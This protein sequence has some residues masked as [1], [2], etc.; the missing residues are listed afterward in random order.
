VVRNET[1]LLDPS[2]LTARAKN[3]VLDT[4]FVP[5]LA[6]GAAPDCLN[7]P[8]V[9]GVHA[10]LPLATHYLGCPLGETVNSCITLGDLHLLR[11]N[12]E[13]EATDESGLARQLQ[14]HRALA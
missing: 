4:I 8:A 13:G 5:A 11:A 7:F 3:S 2:N 10:G 1:A 9:I 6:E 12:V 14:L